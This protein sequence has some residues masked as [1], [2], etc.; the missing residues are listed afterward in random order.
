LTLEEGK[1]SQG[2]N[3]QKRQKFRKRKKTKQG[4]P[5]STTT[6]D[7]PKSVT[8]NEKSTPSKKRGG[9]GEKKGAKKKKRMCATP[10]PQKKTQGN[11][12]V[13]ET[14]SKKMSKPM[15]LVGSKSVLCG[16]EQVGGGRSKKGIR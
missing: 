10:V 16:G 9:W 15:P 2:C 5:R 12:L 1:Y 8:K 14:P 3:S 4:G 11:L 7:R 6:N 13:G